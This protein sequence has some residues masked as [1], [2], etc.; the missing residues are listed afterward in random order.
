MPRPPTDDL[1]GREL[2]VMHVF[3]AVGECDAAE[4]RDRLTDAGTDLSP[5]TV[6]NLVRGLAD[7]GCLEATNRRR[8][9]RYRPARTHE[10]VSR[11]LL[12][13][14]LSRVFRGSREQLLMR[15]MEQRGLTAAECEFL[16]GVLREGRA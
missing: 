12:G 5:P 16:E 11:G 6:G 4:V 9:F 2:E 7:K 3:W 15:L 10:D 1:T 13:D 14:V 8:P